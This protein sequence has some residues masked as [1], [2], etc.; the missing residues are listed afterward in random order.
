M[1]RYRALHGTAKL[2]VVNVE[3]VHYNPLHL[4]SFLWIFFQRQDSWLVPTAGIQSQPEGGLQK[5][6]NLWAHAGTVSEPVHAQWARA[7]TTSQWTHAG[8]VS[9]W[10]RAGTVS[11]PMQKQSVSL[12]RNSQS[13]S[14]CTHSQSVSLCRNSQSVSLCSHSQ[15]LH[16]SHFLLVFLGA[17]SHGSLFPQRC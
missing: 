3:S 16:L 14:L 5:S 2:M 17:L 4:L 13:V 15:P 6:S 8:T 10:A 7:R 11:E 1:T 9:L 12:C